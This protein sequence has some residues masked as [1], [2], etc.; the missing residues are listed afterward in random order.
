M[1]YYSKKGDVII[2]AVVCMSV[3]AIISLLDKAYITSLL[4]I[5]VT[6]YFVW[7][8]FDTYYV[9]Q[10]NKLWYRSALLKGVIDIDT[11]VEII[12]NKS[13]Y[14]GVKPALS[15]KGIV[16]KYNRWDEIYISPKNADQFINT[17]K[18]INQ[19]IRVVE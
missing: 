9:I 1:R 7:M 14:S 2:F 17:L 10:D 16:I 11:I 5:S 18:T 4:L 8:W 12:K 6:A 3:L 15:L 13:S 19:N